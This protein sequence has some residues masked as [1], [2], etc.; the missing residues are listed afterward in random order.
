[1]ILTK[2]YEEFVETTSLRDGLYKTVFSRIWE[3]LDKIKDIKWIKLK[4]T[5]DDKEYTTDFT[6]TKTVPLYIVE[7]I[8]N[9]I[10]KSYSFPDNSTVF[11]DV[12]YKGIPFIIKCINDKT[13]IPEELEFIKEMDIFKFFLVTKRVFD[14]F[15]EFDST[16]SFVNNFKTRVNSVYT[17]LQKQFDKRLAKERID[18][19]EISTE[20]IASTQSLVENLKNNRKD[21]LTNIESFRES[22]EKLIADKNS[23]SKA[24]RSRRGLEAERDS[25][26]LEHESL[27]ETYTEYKTKFD[28]VV[29]LISEID[30]ELEG[31]VYLKTN[32]TNE[33]NEE[34]H[35]F[36]LDRKELILKDKDSVISMATDTKGLMDSIS[37][38]LISLGNMIRKI[39][40]YSEADVV[41]LTEKINEKEK[42]L[43]D[44]FIALTSTDNEI[45]HQ[46]SKSIS[47]SIEVEVTRTENN[48][49][50]YTVGI[51]D[52][53]KKDITNHLSTSLQP[54]SV[55]V[56]M[57]YLRYYFAYHVTKIAA[58][59]VDTYPNLDS[60]VL[61]AIACKLV[62][63]K[64]FGIL[65]SNVF[66]S[67][68][69]VDNRIN[70]ITLIK[71]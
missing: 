69:F 4:Y 62:L 48:I 46:T 13:T 31:L 19:G 10:D 53:E 28:K 35:K 9:L 24:V 33:Y 71:D 56:V 60:S 49:N 37:V 7:I 6:T 18:L 3:V 58:R 52:I 34:F 51:D 23:I 22:K 50:N 15:S 27:K 40:R 29:D 67:V 70:K 8:Q 47:E 2:I 38:R 11:L 14:V 5:I 63:A 26:K 39:E 65:Y 61:Q 45:K 68:N 57:N 32:N 1:M 25:L 59:L 44:F 64:N 12:E 17:P 41:S 43:N 30:V 55:T 21:I 20:K 42:K 36:L 54:A 66:S 16:F